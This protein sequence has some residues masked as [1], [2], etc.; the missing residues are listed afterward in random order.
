[1]SKTNEETRTGSLVKTLGLML[2]V[3]FIGLLFWGI[4]L[5]FGGV[6]WYNSTLGHWVVHQEACACLLDTENFKVLKNECHRKIF[7][8]DGRLYGKSGKMVRLLDPE[9]GRSMTIGYDEIFEKNNK[10]YGKLGD[11]REQIGFIRGFK[12]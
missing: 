3:V 9:S 4:T 10:L 8:K 5:F 1:M 2:S 12:N 11:L 6:P 7:E